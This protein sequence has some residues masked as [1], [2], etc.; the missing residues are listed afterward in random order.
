[1]LDPRLPAFRAAARPI[2]ERYLANA[3]ALSAA[4]RAAGDALEAR[5]ARRALTDATLESFVFRIEDGAR[6]KVGAAEARAAATLSPNVALRPAVQDGVLPTVVMACGPGEIAYLAQLAEVFAGVGVR[7]A[8]PVPRFGATWLPPSAVEL[9][10]V[11]GAEPW[12]LVAGADAVLR[13]QSERAV[14]EAVRAELE[15]SHRATLEGLERF[16]LASAGVDASLPQMVESAR[17]KVDYQ[18]QRLAEG[19]AGKVRHQLER[20]HPQWSKLRYYLSPGDKLQERRLAGLE[21]VSFRGARA[22][23]ELVALAT[24]HAERLESGV[25]EHA[26]LDLA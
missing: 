4:A 25:H 5:G 1:M 7:A 9:L 19:L 16:A 22:A 20:R 13:A 11:S 15:Q 8:A 17:G 23:A 6:V 10:D 14:P 24:A 26:V 18:F 12:E 3:G 21:L 2:L